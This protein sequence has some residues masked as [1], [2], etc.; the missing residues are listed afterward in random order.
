MGPLP[1]IILGAILGVAGLVYRIDWMQQASILLLILN[2]FNLLPVLPF[3][4]GWILHSILFT[5]HHFLDL[6]FRVLAI[7]GL[8]ALG[9][10]MGAKLLAYIAIPM[11]IALPATYKLARIATKLRDSHLPAMSLDQ[12]SI[13]VQTVDTIVDEIKAAFDKYKAVMTDKLLAQH[14]L[15]VFETLNAKP[16]G[17]FASLGFS[18]VHLVSIVVAVIVVSFVITA[19]QQG[20]S[21]MIRALQEEVHPIEIQEIAKFGAVPEGT[22]THTIVGSFTSLKDLNRA[23]DALTNNLPAEAGVLRFGESLLVAVPAGEDGSRN[24]LLDTLGA[25]T[26]NSFV[27]TDRGMAAMS[28]TCKFATPAEARSMADEINEYVGAPRSFGLV[29]PWAGTAAVLTAEQVLARK[30]Y[31]ALNQSFW[32]PFT[33]SEAMEIRRQR[34]AAERK[35]NVSEMKELDA[36]L[37]LLNEELRKDQF[38]EFKNA[39]AG[40]YDVELANLYAEFTGKRDR[41][42]GRIDPLQT[43]MA[44]RMGRFAE[45]D[46]AIRM[47]ATFEGY[48]TA[49]QD[50]LV[51]GTLPFANAFVGPERFVRWLAEHGGKNMTYGFD[52]L[53]WE[54]ISGETE[55]A[56]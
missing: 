8:I 52:F 10:A 38:D 33:N 25:F 34:T 43:K 55:E 32:K 35:G 31:V 50:E 42:A 48:A 56:E 14:T 15:S 23:L 46:H 1:G 13:P 21:A 4:G 41:V 28:L 16:P 19:K 24:R 47:M 53:S 44:E 5:R 27:A 3:D 49:E 51:I 17:W 20:Y 11:A 40:K 2:G 7:A 37:E 39:P 18:A 26:T 30:T 9:I 45:T 6:A 22:E 29:P 54:D 36:K 12:Q